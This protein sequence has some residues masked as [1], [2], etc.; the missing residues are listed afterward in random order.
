[1]FGVTVLTGLIF[2]LAPALLASRPDLVA[3][4]KGSGPTQSG[5]NKATSIFAD[6]WWLRRVAIS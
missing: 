1:M 3:V 4:L 2:G 5:G 6:C